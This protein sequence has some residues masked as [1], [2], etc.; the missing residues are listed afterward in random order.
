MAHTYS[1][2]AREAAR[3]FDPSINAYMAPWV[4]NGLFGFL[5]ILQVM[6]IY[7]SYLILRVLFRYVSDP[8]VLGPCLIIVHSSTLRGAGTSDDRSDDEDAE[9]AE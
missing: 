6:S 3:R 2:T 9:K 7:W 1:F 5:S 4:R 8:S